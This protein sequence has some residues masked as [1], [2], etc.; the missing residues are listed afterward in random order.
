VE[1]TTL[2]MP[3]IRRQGN[4]NL[5][6]VEFYFGFYLDKVSITFRNYFNDSTVRPCSAESVVTADA[7]LLFYTRRIA[8]NDNMVNQAHE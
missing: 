7:Y 6:F 2:H 1:G 3:N 8:D 4:G 5:A